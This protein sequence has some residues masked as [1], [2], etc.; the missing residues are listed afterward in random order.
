MTGM[1]AVVI[2]Y[3]LSPLNMFPAQLLDALYSYLFLL[4]QGFEQE[5]IVL[6]GESSGGNLV[7]VLALLLRHLGIGN[8]RGTVLI[9]PWA[10]L[11]CTSRSA[12]ENEDF[13]YLAFPTVEFPENP[14]RMFYAP[15][16][17]LT[18]DLVAELRHSLVSPL[19]GDFS[20][21]PPTLIQAGTRERLYDDIAKLYEKMSAQNTHETANIVFEA[22]DDMIHVFQQFE[23]APDTEIAYA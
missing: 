13:D 4:D 16:H 5:N 18:E 23:E 10:E 6:A 15:G 8:V 12:V 21:F 9:S 14:G 20:N 3:R 11:S 7:L 19:Y 17:R 1:R 2:D 22:Y